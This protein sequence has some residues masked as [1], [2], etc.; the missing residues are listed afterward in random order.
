MFE[1]IIVGVDG[2]QGGRDA[3]ALAQRLAGP[4]ARITL[5]CVYGSDW[6][7]GRGAGEESPSARAE[8]LKL[9]TREREQAGVSAE[10]APA[11]DRPVGQG[12]HELAEACAAD[13]LVVGSSR[14][15]PLGRVLLGDDTHAALDGAPCAVAVAPQSYAES[16][17]AIVSIGVGYDGSPGGARALAAARELGEALAAEVTVL[18]VVSLQELSQAHPQPA[19]WQ[20]GAAEMV[21]E[22]ARQLAGLSGVHGQATYGGPREELEQF[23]RRVDLLVLGSRGYGPWERVFH[24]SISGH[25]IRHAACPVLVLAHRATEPA[26]ELAEPARPVE[27]SV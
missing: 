27:L 24:G 17:D 5:A 7:L 4:R 2:R 25:V 6:L 26:N 21:N 22:R 8:A 1:N 10:L 13:L 18:W 3:I 9:L 15:A 19:D 23:S 16:P 12:L 11:G 20:R 14:R